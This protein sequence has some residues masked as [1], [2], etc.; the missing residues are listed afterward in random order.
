MSDPAH[1]IEMGKESTHIA[2]A[3]E[4]RGPIRSLGSLAARKPRFVVLREWLGEADAEP[5]SPCARTL[6]CE[7][8]YA[9]AD[10]ARW[11]SVL[12]RADFEDVA[13]S[14]VR[15]SLRTVAARRVR[16]ELAEGN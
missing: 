16:G 10:L 2:S 8:G 11:K 15:R 12:R 13:E 7:K 14:V 3:E 4:G 5:S 1:H 6:S 9:C